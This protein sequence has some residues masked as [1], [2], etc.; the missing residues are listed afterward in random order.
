[1]LISLNPGQGRLKPGYTVDINITT[2]SKADGLVVPYEAVLESGKTQEIFVVE[3]G[4]AR[5][6]SVH[7]GISNELYLTVDKGLNK[8]DKVIV[9]PPEKLKDGSL[10]KETPYQTVKPDG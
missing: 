1:M 6:R 5:K 4:K 10:V 3:K 9:S 7:T 8:G 2:A